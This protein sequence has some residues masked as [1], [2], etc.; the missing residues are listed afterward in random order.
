M[1]GFDYGAAHMVRQMAIRIPFEA[2]TS[3]MMHCSY[4]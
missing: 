3:Q 4:P 1:I 2:R